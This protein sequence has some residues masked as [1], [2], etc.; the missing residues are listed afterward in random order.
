[1]VINP[2]TKKRERI[3]KVSELD[4]Y[5]KTLLLKDAF[6]IVKGE[7]EKTAGVFEKIYPVSEADKSYQR[8]GINDEIRK[9]F[10]RLCR[11]LIPDYLNLTQ[12]ESMRE[13]GSLKLE[14]LTKTDFTRTFKEHAKSGN[15]SLMNLSQ[16]N[17]ALDTLSKHIYPSHVSKADRLSRLLSLLQEPN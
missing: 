13:M 4:R 15:K 2:E 17:K 5:L 9:V 6:L 12:F 3:K 1:M 16:F 8:F 7:E 11:P 14:A 10:E